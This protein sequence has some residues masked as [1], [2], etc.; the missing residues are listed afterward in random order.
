MTFHMSR[1]GYKY[2]LQIIVLIL[3]VDDFQINLVFILLGIHSICCIFSGVETHTPSPRNELFSI[4]THSSQKSCLQTLTF[5]IS[6]YS[7]Y[8][9]VYSLKSLYTKITILC[10]SLQIYYLAVIMIPAIPC[11]CAWCY[12]LLKLKI[13]VDDHTLHQLLYM[14][15]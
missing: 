11:Q 9:S 13:N 5:G 12:I 3:V 8:I 7:L 2:Q 4:G 15:D 14:V 6:V 10:Q 1:G